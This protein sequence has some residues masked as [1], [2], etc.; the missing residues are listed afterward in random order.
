MDTL[1]LAGRPLTIRRAVRADVP[2]VVALLSDDVLGRER[3]DADLGPYLAAFDRIEAQGGNEVIVVR[4]AAGTLLATLQ[5][6]LLPSLSRSGITRLQIEAVRVAADAR[7]G[8][9]GTAMLFWAHAWGRERGARLV[10]LTTDVA[11]TDAR[12]FYENLGYVPS[13]VGLKREL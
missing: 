6:M 13:H 8:G 2:E 12:R 1:D 3:E 9:L 5:L 11:R 10:Q 7:G 4:D